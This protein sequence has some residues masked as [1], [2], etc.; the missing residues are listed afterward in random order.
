MFSLVC[1]KVAFHILSA[2]AHV[3]YRGKEQTHSQRPTHLVYFSFVWLALKHWI[4]LKSKFDYYKGSCGTTFLC[5]FY[6]FK[7]VSLCKTYLY[8]FFNPFNSVSKKEEL[9]KAQMQNNLIFLTDKIS[10]PVF[11][12]T[13]LHMSTRLWPQ[14]AGDNGCLTRCPSQWNPNLVFLSVYW[15][16][17]FQAKAA[18]VV[19]FRFP[20]LQL[21][22]QCINTRQREGATE[23][24]MERGVGFFCLHPI[25][26]PL[27]RGANL[28]QWN[29]HDAFN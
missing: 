3:A 8:I 19:D 23:R 7:S 6:V 28:K 25:V 4:L 24:A 5:V 2:S 16:P 17:A 22:Y 13:L 12:P 1:L 15:P 27:V 26:Q 9:S 18:W 11:C 29:Q 21:P 20:P 14:S 10:S